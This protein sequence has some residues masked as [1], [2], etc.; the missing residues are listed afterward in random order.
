M[1]HE[2]FGR[3]SQRSREPNFCLSGI[4][5]LEG[6]GVA[7]ARVLV[8]DEVHDLAD[9]RPVEPQHGLSNRRIDACVERGR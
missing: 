5:A 1:P 8:D 2:P 3:A 6:L 9:A 7:H 4:V